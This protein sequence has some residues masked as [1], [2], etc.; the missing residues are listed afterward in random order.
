MDVMVSRSPNRSAASALPTSD[1]D[2]EAPGRAR[3]R[4]TSLNFPKGS[5]TLSI[6]LHLPGQ[7]D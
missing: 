1:K 2:Q 4:L 5:F 6:R 7:V 3:A